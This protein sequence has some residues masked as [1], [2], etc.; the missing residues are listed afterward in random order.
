MAAVAAFF[1]LSIACLLML[2]TWPA[3]A[4]PTFSL[5]AGPSFIGGYYATRDSTASAFIEAVFDAHRIGTSDFRWAPDAMVGWI[6][7]RNRPHTVF[8]RYAI[9]D[10]IWL[11]AGG[12][13]F[14][15]GA[16]DAWYRHLFFSFQPTVHTGLTPGMSSWYEFTFTAGWQARHWVLAVRH[17]SNAWLR[18][19]NRGEDMLLVGITF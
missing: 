14:T 3:V 15:Y 19:P 1:R 17:S 5:E 2:A 9:H 16:D 11:L 6:D 13:R 7:G 12:A 18:M 8:R 10:R 4:G